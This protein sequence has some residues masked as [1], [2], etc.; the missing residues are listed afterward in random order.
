ME[1][2]MNLP[3]SKEPSWMYWLIPAPGVGLSVFKAT[4]AAWD[5]KMNQKKRPGWYVLGK[6]LQTVMFLKVCS[7]GQNCGIHS[8]DLLCVKGTTTVLLN[9]NKSLGVWEVTVLEIMNI[10]KQGWVRTSRTLPE[11]KLPAVAESSV[12]YCRWHSEG[13]LEGNDALSF[14]LPLFWQ[15]YGSKQA[16]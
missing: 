12:T 5:W 4:H 14:W 6:T 15:W 1:K 16:F 9:V 3:P 11:I 2:L 8:N 10:C 7:N 13:C